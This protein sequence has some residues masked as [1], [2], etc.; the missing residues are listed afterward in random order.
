[1][2]TLRTLFFVGIGALV[3]TAFSPPSVAGSSF[4]AGEVCTVAGCQQGCTGGSGCNAYSKCEG[5][6]C[7]PTVLDVT[8]YTDDSVLP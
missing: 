6:E 5:A 8:C 2:G 1:M 7:K 4:A 3:L